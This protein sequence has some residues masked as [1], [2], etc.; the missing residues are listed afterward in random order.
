MTAEGS[1]STGTSHLRKYVDAMETMDKSFD[2]F[3]KLSAGLDDM[4][5]GTPPTSPSN[6]DSQD[7]KSRNSEFVIALTNDTDTTRT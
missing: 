3:S 6:A 4:T 5:Y 2:A 7:E 1:R